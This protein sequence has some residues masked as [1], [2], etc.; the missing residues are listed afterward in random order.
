MATPAVHTWLWRDYPTG[1]SVITLTDKHAF[2]FVSVLV[3]LVAFGGDAIWNLIC[4]TL[5]TF[6]LF[7]DTN[8]LDQLLK[9]DSSAFEVLPKLL[10]CLWSDSSLRKRK[11]VWMLL[12]VVFLLGGRDTYTVDIR[13][14][15][16][17]C[18]YRRNSASHSGVRTWSWRTLED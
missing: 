12:I 8:D 2:L 15:G 14:L 16:H 17:Y 18:R 4:R 5:S 1:N 10:H 13:F 6:E 9:A 7:H 11:R 3:L